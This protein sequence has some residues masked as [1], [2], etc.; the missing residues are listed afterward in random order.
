MAR[1]LPLVGVSITPQVKPNSDWYLNSVAKSS[2]NTPTTNAP[3]S[4]GTAIGGRTYSFTTRRG[5]TYEL[6]RVESGEAQLSVDNSDGLFDPNNTTSTLYPNVVP[7]RPITINCAYPLTGNI[8]NN[9]NLAPVIKSGSPATSADYRVSVSANDSN[10][11]LGTISNWRTSATSGT[12][13]FLQIVATPHTGTYAM[14]LKGT[15]PNAVLDVP[16]VP[17]KQVCVSLWYRMSGAGTTATMYV[18]DG[19]NLN[20]N[21][22][23]GNVSM[24]NTLTYTQKYVTVT[25]QTDKIC[26]YIL[27]NNTTADVYIDDVQVEFGATPTTNVITGPTVYS[28]FHGFVERYPQTYQAPNRG[29]ANM[30]A[31][32]ALASISN[33]TMTSPYVAMV[34]QDSYPALYYYPLSEPSG[35]AG[36]YNAGLSNQQPMTVTTYGTASTLAFGDASAQT[37]IPGAGTTGVT[38]NTINSAGINK[39]NGT[40][41]QTINV[42]DLPYSL[43]TGTT[44]SFWVKMP[45]GVTNTR[46]FSLND[47]NNTGKNSL[48]V[49]VDGS[50]KLIIVDADG[51]A[52]TAGLGSSYSSYIPN[53]WMYVSL[54][55]W[56]SAGWFAY[57]TTSTGT[58]NAGVTAITSPTVF[59]NNSV[60]SFAIG[61]PVVSSVSSVI[62]HVNV[63]RGAAVQP[64]FNT[65]YSVGSAGLSGESTGTRFGDLISNYSGFKYLPYGADYGK[66]F[67][68][69]AITDGQN[70]FDVL[71]TTTDTEGGTW[72]VDADGFT[73]FK[74]RWNRLQKLLP[75]VTFGDGANE[76]PYEGG[77]LVINYDPTFVINNVD[78]KRVGG[79]N[80]TAN[81]PTS[82]ANY[83]TRSY[84]RTIQNQSDSTASDASYFLLSR[85]KDPHARPETI[86]LTPARNPAIWSQVLNLE[87]GDLV[88]V[89]KRPLTWT[90]SG[91]TTANISIDCFVERVEHSFDAQSADWVTT[92]SLSPT[93][94][95]YWNLAAMR[96]TTTGSAVSGSF[97]F[98][99]SATTG[100]GLNSAR[101]I[102]P[103]QM[104]QYTISG[105]TYVDV[106]SGAPTETATTVTVPAIR[107]TTFTNATKPV[108]VVMQGFNPTL[109]K[110]IPM[111]F[112]GTIT[113]AL[114]DSSILNSYTTFL[115]DEELFT[116]SNTGTSLTL[117]AR[118][119]NST[120]QTAQGSGLTTADTATYSHFSGATVYGVLG[121]AG[122]NVPTG[123]VVTEFL[124]NQ[125]TQLPYSVPTYTNYDVTSVLGSWVGTLNTAGYTSST[126]GSVTYNTL[127]LSALVD[128]DN[129]PASDIAVGQIFSIG[130][131]N[132]GC[133]TT[134][135]PSATTQTWTLSG[136]KITDSG[137]TLNSNTTPDQNTIPITGT[138]PASGTPILVG[139]EWMTVTGGATGSWAVT[140]GTPQSAVWGVLGAYPHY[141]YDKVYTG[142]LAG[143]TGTYAV[144]Q[145]VIEGY[146]VTTP[147]VGTARLGY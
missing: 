77:D 76:T 120:L 47:T 109:T 102:R 24:P 101:D 9:N 118:A 53:T 50:G 124:T 125:L 73:V 105:T 56:Y 108:G 93:I 136:Y 90:S 26:I 81:D 131:E 6:G 144:G 142:V 116:G 46:I 96:A 132:F 22:S 129:Y 59:N 45:A 110:N 65:Y 2:V 63:Q 123:T 111:D 54:S 83:F 55:T 128:R 84:T 60:T 34:L 62:A 103:G 18:Y 92:V 104:L 31:T 89:N 13:M 33:V 86:K 95:Y 137:A 61:A 134:G 141:Q 64:N 38:T 12:G 146:N 121:T 68:S 19:S 133:V 126:T 14:A 25:P 98:T 70:M 138:P 106:V 135:V 78:V 1:D 20:A 40:Y 87:I 15:T 57:L 39:L 67:M 35:S 94:V 43:T 140:R 122:G 82:T 100:A 21:S 36:G 37:G 91:S 75:S 88:R 79:A 23:L 119:Q 8:L 112:T 3:K 58:N 32:D 74:D 139:G 16:V 17:G 97:V 51:T 48:G 72:Y 147:I 71:Q 130:S 10:F 44:F 85:Y 69:T 127:T 49:A 30:V 5:R 80:L 29:Q 27:P 11:E 145:S 66:D 99:K 4:M 28:L 143:L 115:I 107:V 113:S 42:Q 52:L 41:L 7:Y 114:S 117:T